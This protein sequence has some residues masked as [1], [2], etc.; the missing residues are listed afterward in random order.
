MRTVTELDW[1]L[2]NFNLF[3]HDAY[4]VGGGYLQSHPVGYDEK[5][6]FFRA[7]FRVSKQRSFDDPEPFF[8]LK[9]F[10]QRAILEESLDHLKNLISN[11]FPEVGIDDNLIQADFDYY[12]TGGGVTRV[13]TYRDGELSL[14]TR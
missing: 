5:G 7:T 3:W 12:R 2:L 10:E 14:M 6:K 11:F 4:R 13:A 1:S 8:E 9:D